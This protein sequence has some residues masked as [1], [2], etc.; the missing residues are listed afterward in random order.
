MSREKN[1]S[2]HT[3]LLK[4]VEEAFNE[5]PSETF[6]GYLNALIKENKRLDDNAI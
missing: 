6:K 4:K 1:E 5:M 3:Y 2:I